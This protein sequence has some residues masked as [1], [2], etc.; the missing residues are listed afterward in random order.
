MLILSTGMT[1]SFF[2]I[3]AENNM[4]HLRMPQSPRVSTFDELQHQER[5]A[6]LLFT[7]SFVPCSDGKFKQACVYPN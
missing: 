2:V 7:T 5:V 1:N 3:C 6:L 4:F